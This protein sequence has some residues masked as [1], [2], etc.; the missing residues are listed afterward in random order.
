MLSSSCLSVRTSVRPHGTTL[1]PLDVLSY[2]LIN[3]QLCISQAQQ[4]FIMVIIVLGQHVSILI[5]LS[6]VPSKIQILNYQC[7]KCAVGSQT[8]NKDL[9]LRRT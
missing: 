3:I 8:L 6:S 7:L 9:Y 1:L 4:N 5:E 2:N